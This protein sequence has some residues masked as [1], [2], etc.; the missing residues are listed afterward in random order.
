MVAV[1]ITVMVAVALTVT[2]TSKVAVTVTATVTVT[3]AVTVTMTAEMEEREEEEESR[4]GAR[5]E[6]VR[7]QRLP[8]QQHQKQQ[9]HQ[10][11]QQERPAT[12][13][14][15]RWAMLRR[16]RL[17]WRN[18][19]GFHALRRHLRGQPRWKTRRGCCP[20]LSGYSGTF[21]WWVGLAVVGGL[22]VMVNSRRPRFDPLARCTGLRPPIS[23]SKQ[24]VGKM[25]TIGVH[26]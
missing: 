8:Q 9:Q 20:R 24:K 23:S 19:R 12:L 3:A 21:T 7:A 16:F 17:S 14:W 22:G 13:R 6:T 5:N 2:A 26:R 25:Q 4:G 11:R 10:H 15:P 1:T 18:G